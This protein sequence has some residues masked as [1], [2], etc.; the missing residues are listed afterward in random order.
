MNYLLIREVTTKQMA[1]K[2]NKE[3]IKVRQLNCM[4]FTKESFFNSKTVPY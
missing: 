1:V 3:K 4:T 2:C